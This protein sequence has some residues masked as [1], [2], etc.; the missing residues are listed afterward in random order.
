MSRYNSRRLAPIILTIVVIIVSIALLVSLARALLFSGSSSTGQNQVVD[1][2]QEALLNTDANRSVSMTV[3]GPIV[4][5][6]DFRSYQITISPN[7][8]T[9]Q[10]YKGYLGTILQQKTRTNNAAAYEEFVFALNKANMTKGTQFEDDQNDVRGVC[11]PGRVYEYRLLKDGKSVEMLWASTCSGSKGSLEASV[12]QLT[13]L[14]VR[15]IP[16]ARDIIHDL[17]I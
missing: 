11:A 12:D 1:T 13:E 7:T 10:T 6:E 2:T 8:R 3:R 15:Q 9:I 4:A 16:E 17:S 5:D 14:F